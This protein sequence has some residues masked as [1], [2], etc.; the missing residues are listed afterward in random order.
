MTSRAVWAAEP[1]I[2]GL[3]MPTL[4]G[5]QF[6]ADELLFHQWRIQRNVRDNHYRLLDGK[7]FRYAWGT[8]AECRAKLEQIKRRQKLP[9]M[10][11]KA[12]IVLHGLFRSRAAMDKLCKYFQQQG[13]Y[14][15]FNVGYPSTQSDVGSHARALGQIIENLEGIEEINFVAHSMGNIVIRHYLADRTRRRDPRLKRFVMLAPPNHGALAALALAENRAFQWITGQSGQQ[16]GAEWA[17]L[18]GHLATPEFEFGIIAGGRGNG[19]GYN[20]LLPGD[21]DGTISVAG[22]RLAGARDFVV[23]P[24]LHTFIV[25]DATVHQY[26]LRFFQRGHFISARKRQPLPKE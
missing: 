23:L 3:R 6:W 19:K 25:N 10:K 22:T 4:G 12:V 11:G 15:V 8:F 13:G 17:K 18:E 2:P 7:N 14:A 26:T 24:L 16:L 5:K 20:P 9:P 1:L 21:D